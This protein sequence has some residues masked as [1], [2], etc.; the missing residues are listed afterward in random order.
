M[1]FSWA[2]ALLTLD[3]ADIRPPS[4]YFTCLS[5]YM[6]TVEMSK[7]LAEIERFAGS[8]A[9]RWGYTGSVEP[10]W[11]TLFFAVLEGEEKR[12]FQGHTMQEYQEKVDLLMTSMRSMAE[13]EG[14]AA[15]WRRWWRVGLGRLGMLYKDILALTQPLAR[16]VFSILCLQRTFVAGRG[17][18]YGFTDGEVRKRDKLALLFP[19]ADVPFVLREKIMEKGEATGSF[20]MVGLARLPERMKAAALRGEEEY[21][22]EII[23]E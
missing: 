20:E 21:W 10:L 7:S 2:D 19:W 23:I 1:L 12:F 11:K 14:Q 22:T 4:E 15:W 3:F 8:R 9:L 13:R 5:Q 16:R 6:H 18:W 17:I